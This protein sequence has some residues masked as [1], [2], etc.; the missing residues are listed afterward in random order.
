[1]IESAKNKSLAPEQNVTVTPKSQIVNDYHFA[2]SGIYKPL[3]VTANTIEEATE[4]WK[5]KR[6][7]VETESEATQ[8]Q[9]TPADKPKQ[10]NTKDQN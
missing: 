8:Y 4:L 7:A 10:E 3:T 2:G 1:M 5:T 6:V 9:P